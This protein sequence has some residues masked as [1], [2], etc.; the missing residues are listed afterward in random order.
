VNAN[1]KSE[2][3]QLIKRYAWAVRIN[4]WLKRGL[5]HLPWLR[6]M[7]QRP[8]APVA[9]ARTDAA[10]LASREEK[11]LHYLDRSG[12][13]LEIG[14]SHNPIA[15]KRLG[16]NVHILDHLSAAGLREK[17]ADHALFGVRIENIEEVDFVW[18]GEDLRDLIGR[19]GCYDWIISS[20]V[21]EHVPDVVS[22]LQQCETL[23]K[24]NGFISLVIPDMRYC[25]DSLGSVSTTGDFLD[26]YYL[27]RT[28]PSLGMIFDHFASACQLNQKIAWD[29]K[30][31]TNNYQL[32]HDFTSVKELCEHV[33][34]KQEY[35]DTHCWRFTPKSFELI[36]GDL[37]RLGL[38][39]VSIV[40]SFE[41]SGCEFYVTLGFSEEQKLEDRLTLLKKV[42]EESS[43]RLV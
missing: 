2:P 14:P 28:R 18:N 5:V 43:F 9:T 29:S 7:V 20:H 32:M 13:G 37:Q 1:R 22:H 6:R 33:Q 39:N 31:P 15:P 26:A 25:F 12:L 36:I 16:F 21:I 35:I 27:K 3:M 10:T 41:T 24:R 8:S 42:K 30:E 40:G 23:I 17:Y 34:T 19:T 11:V 38:L 4:A